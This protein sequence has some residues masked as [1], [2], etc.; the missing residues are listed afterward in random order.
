MVL[1]ESQEVASFVVGLAVVPAAPALLE[2]GGP[3]INDQSVVFEDRKLRGCLT[4]FKKADVVF[5]V[6]PV[7]AAVA[8]SY[9]AG[10]CPASI[11]AENPQE[12]ATRAE[13]R[14][15]QEE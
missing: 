7:E 3:G 1:L 9:S 13:L 4:S 8:Y 10:A 14:E 6:G 5:L 12:S 11:L 2:L 15:Y